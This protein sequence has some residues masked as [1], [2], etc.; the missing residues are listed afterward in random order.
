MTQ[1]FDFEIPYDVFKGLWFGKSIAYN[2]KGDFVVAW[3]SKVAIYWE[4]PFTHLN[5]RQDSADFDAFARQPDLAPFIRLLTQEFDFQIKGKSATG[6]GLGGVT[7]SGAQMTTDTYVFHIIS[8][9]QSWYN[10]QY[11]LTREERRVI[12]PAMDHLGAVQLLIAQQFTLISED[13]PIDYKRALRLDEQNS[14]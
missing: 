2:P 5:Y 4:E 13:V 6:T 8:S 7:N 14:S 12:G 9:M 3:T 11:F 1:I 10:N